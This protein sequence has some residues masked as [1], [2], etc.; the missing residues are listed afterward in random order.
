MIHEKSRIINV[1]EDTGIWICNNLGIEKIRLALSLRFRYSFLSFRFLFS[2]CDSF[3]FAFA[4]L[5]AT[6]C[7][8]EKLIYLPILPRES[9]EFMTYFNSL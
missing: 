8:A 1:G 3:P 7:S 9:L 4:F 2:V 5:L 6:P